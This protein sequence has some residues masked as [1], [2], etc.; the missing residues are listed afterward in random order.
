[1]NLPVGK[2]YLINDTS[3][4]LYQKAIAINLLRDKGFGNVYNFDPKS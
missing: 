3:N 4:M 2:R 1:M